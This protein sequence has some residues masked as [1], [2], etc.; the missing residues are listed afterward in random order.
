VYTVHVICVAPG[1]TVHGGISR[2]IGKIEH[3][4]PADIDFQV[5]PTCSG[6]IPDLRRFGWNGVKQ[7]VM[8]VSCLLRVL[9]RAVFTRSAIFHLHFSQEG[10]TLR[11]GILCIILR[12]LRCTYVVHGHACEDAIV[13]RWLPNAVTECLFWGL[14][15]A[16][17]F[18]ALTPFWRQYYL[19]KGIAAPSRV[20]ILPTPAQLPNC[21]PARE[22]KHPIEF[23]FLGRVGVRKGTFDLI[24][25]FVELPLPVRSRCRL[26][27]AGDGEVE[28]ARSLIADLGCAGSVTVLGWVG[29]ERVDQ[30]L[31]QADVLFLPSKAEGMSQALLEGMAWELAVVTTAVGGAQE[32]LRN[33]HNCILVA[34]N[35]PHGI[36]SAMVRLVENAELRRSLGKEARTTVRR[37]GIDEYVERLATVYRELAQTTT[38]MVPSRSA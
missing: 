33:D 17:R 30:L 16:H 2:L 25:A 28:Q 38:S 37:F 10:S 7:L 9:Y 15:G 13:H 4:F 6:Y 26:T 8:F 14:R 18:I 22:P 34:P 27:I 20:I 19:D 12:S 24:S 5:I 1:K 31:S 23:L 35:D 29:G 3:S 36:S 21:V 32:F 11:K